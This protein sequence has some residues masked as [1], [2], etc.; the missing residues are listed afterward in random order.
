M[1]KIISVK[2]AEHSNDIVINEEYIYKYNYL[3]NL[4]NNGLEYEHLNSEYT[5]C[6]IAIDSDLELLDNAESVDDLEGKEQLMTYREKI[7]Q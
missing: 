7:Q 4:F 2:R 1:S 6:L 3:L 5:N